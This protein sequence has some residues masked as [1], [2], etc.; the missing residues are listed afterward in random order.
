MVTVLVAVTTACG[1]GSQPT[2]QLSRAPRLLVAPTNASSQKQAC[3]EAA[4]SLHGH[5]GVLGAQVTTVSALAANPYYRH[6]GAWRSL[7]G[8]TSVLACVATSPPPDAATA[9]TQMCKV[10]RC[11]TSSAS[12]APSGGIFF[13]CGQSSAG[14]S[15]REQF[16]VVDT[17]HQAIPLGTR[18]MGH[19]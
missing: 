16:Y 11:G 12:P 5:W 8:H 9:R 19:C 17:N 1:S 13:A 7:P 6:S 10:L 4:S 2:S 3:A 15:L 14:D 18:G